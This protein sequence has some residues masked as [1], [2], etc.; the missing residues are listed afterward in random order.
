M[1]VSPTNRPILFHDLWN[2]SPAGVL[3]F[4]RFAPDRSRSDPLR[5][6]KNEKFLEICKAWALL[7]LQISRNSSRPAAFVPACGLDFAWQEVDPSVSE[8]ALP[9]PDA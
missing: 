6:A 9:G 3:D 8:H 2:P 7:P 5:L 4:K 1:W